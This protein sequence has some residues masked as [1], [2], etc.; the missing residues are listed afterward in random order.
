MGYQQQLMAGLEILGSILCPPW[1]IMYLSYVVV[2]VHVCC[3]SVP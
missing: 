2:M 1:T 3:G